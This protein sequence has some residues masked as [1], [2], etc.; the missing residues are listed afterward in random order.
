MFIL[1]RVCNMTRKVFLITTLLILGFSQ[2]AQSVETELWDIFELT[3]K[4]PSDGNPFADVTLSAEFTQGEKIFEPAGFYDG[5]GTYKIRFM[6]DKTGKWTFTT[7]SNR[8]ELNG[9]KGEFICTKAGPENHGPVR[10]H[11]TFKLAY[12]DGTPH[13][14]VGT[15]CYAW[16]HQG[17]K[18]EEQTL[19]T[20]ANAPFNKMRMCVFPKSYSYNKNEPEYYAYEGKPQK[21]WDLKRFNPA[22]WHHFEK[23][24]EQLRD[25]GIEADIII[26]HPYDRWDFKK[27][28]HENNLFYLKYLVARL[29]AYRNVWWSF[30]NEF[31][32]LKWPTEHW[33]QYMELVQQIDPYDRLRGIHNCRTWYD[34][35][36]PW[37][38]HC[39]IQTSDF[40]SA[41]NF[42]EK[43]NKP[44]LYDEC[45]YEGNIS[46][47]WGRITAEQMTR[48]FWMGSLAGCYV[49]H[50]ETYKHPED[51]LW[52]AKGG[53]LRGKSPA[54]IQFMKDIIQELP[55]RQME[56]DF[57]QH[58]DVCILAKEA[59]CY[60]LYFASK[61]Q[62]TLDLPSG[63]PFKVDGIDTWD[64]KVLPVGSASKGT[65]TFTPPK[66][67]YAIRLTRY[68]PGEKMRP[69]AKAR[70]DKA[71]GIAPL[72]VAFSTPWEQE[73][74]WDFGDTKS[75]TDRSPVHTFA[76][77]GIYTVVLTITDPDGGV[78]CATLGVR[79]DR[80]SKDAVVKFGFADGDY[81]K[82]TLHGGKVTRSPNGS[83]DLGSGKPFTWIKVGEK[84]IRELEG[85]QSFTITGWLKASGMKIGAGGN[86]ILF[87]LQ[88]SRAGM[89]L[90][91]H[92]N[93]A[94]RLAVNEWPDSIKNDSSAGKVQIGKWVFFG[95]TYDASKRNDNVC[96]YF[97]DENTQAKL[98]RKTDYN[99]GSVDEGSANLVIGNFNKTL[100]GAGLDR[101]FRGQIRG[102]QIYA[103]RL[104]GRG[105]LK[106][107]KI[108]ELQKMR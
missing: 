19:E 43:Y 107:D 42:R 52:W 59:E 7:K 13:F 28:G 60:L 65:F 20:L 12:A 50:G 4:G 1:E 21:S 101:Q 106:L 57:G 6:P 3:L 25:M 26:F 9:R 40:K 56:P 53:V 103:S 41:G 33:D 47:G 78:G 46:Q 86:R 96:W 68:A 74:S 49:G 24:V 104:G 100:Q 88:H 2:G 18:M 84:P 93:G 98:D 14:S 61:K 36:K 102:L 76:E 11:D 87:S 23:R 58:P 31:D 108:R 54:R 75:S 27:M 32:L 91:H 35:S 99:N 30:A 80:N 63:R 92:A 66:Q 44:V 34:H 10:V 22:F 45:K 37:V 48:N 85:S 77:P 16:V 70:A 55:Y 97:G 51:L 81:P 105:A 17:D 89:D 82:V 62:V 39:S 38:T 90:V 71:E 15:T 64:M 73:C 29:A 94:M 67:D 72:T 95:V 8:R 69:E 5:G 83:Y 79:V